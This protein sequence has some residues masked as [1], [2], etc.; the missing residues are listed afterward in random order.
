MIL[1]RRGTVGMKTLRRIAVSSLK[2]LHRCSLGDRFSET[3]RLKRTGTTRRTKM[4]SSKI[5]G[6]RG[7]ILQRTHTVLVTS[8][9]QELLSS[10][11]RLSSSLNK[12]SSQIQWLATRLIIGLISSKLKRCNMCSRSILRRIWI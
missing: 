4:R 3:R 6:F 8:S 5:E 7:R 9:C 1:R 2:A 10:K 12:Y 11:K